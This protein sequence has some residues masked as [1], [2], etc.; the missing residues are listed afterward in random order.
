MTNRAEIE[1]VAR[2]ANPAFDAA[3]NDETRAQWL[4]EA[5]R[6][7]EAIDSVRANRQDQDWPDSGLPGHSSVLCGIDGYVCRRCQGLAPSGFDVKKGKQ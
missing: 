7:I 4:R 6:Y 5:A 3:T 1:A 2:A